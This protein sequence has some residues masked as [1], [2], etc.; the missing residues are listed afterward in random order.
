M[1]IVNIGQTSD[2]Q[3]QIEGDIETE[4]TPMCST[5]SE[6]YNG[7]GDGR[8]CSAKIRQNVFGSRVGYLE[9]TFDESFG[10]PRHETRR[11]SVR[12]YGDSWRK[13]YGLFDRQSS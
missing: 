12:E 1:S 5:G 4:S 3:R 2:V 13:R 9:E 6:H 7:D 11:M 8:P 10:R